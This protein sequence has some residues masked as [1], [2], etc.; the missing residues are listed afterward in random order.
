MSERAVLPI[1]AGRVRSSAGA[2]GPLLLCPQVLKLFVRFPQVALVSDVSLSS[3]QTLPAQ[4]YDPSGSE[5][6][7]PAQGRGGWRSFD[8]LRVVSKVEPQARA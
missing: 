7:N 2:D 1:S 8:R 3:E 4:Y 5:G 6:G